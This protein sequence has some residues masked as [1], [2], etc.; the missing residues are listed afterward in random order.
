MPTTTTNNW[1]YPLPT[2]P[3]KDGA[4]AIQSLAAESDLRLAK[5]G[6][7]YG[8]IGG[9]VADVNGALVVAL[10]RTFTGLPSVTVTVFDTAIIAILL[11]SQLFQDQFTVLFKTLAGAARPG[12]IE[13]SWQ[14]IGPVR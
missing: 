8:A 14:A 6:L 13:F 2:E 4:A 1:P 5:L 3:V 9:G 12:A 10:G 7:A 11:K